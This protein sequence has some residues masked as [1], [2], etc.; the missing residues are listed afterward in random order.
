ALNRLTDSGIVN[1]MESRI[2]PLAKKAAKNLP[3]SDQLYQLAYDNIQRRL[4]AFLSYEEFV[5]QPEKVEELHAM[6]IEAKRLRYTLETFSPLYPDQYHAV[7]AAVRTAQE[8]LGNIHDCDVWV[9]YLPQFI[10]EELQLAFEYFG[11]QHP[12]TSLIPGIEFLK[13]NRQQ[14]RNQEY[15]RFVEQWQSWV[16][17]CIWQRLRKIIHLP[18]ALHST[19]SPPPVP[20]IQDGSP[21]DE[22]P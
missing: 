16:S 18:L 1:E 2:L 21:P 20:T 14:N 22:A 5:P 9:V 15:A 4:E 10:G 19:E 12:L 11:R 3:Y 17:Q 6:R 8:M 13:D 7:V